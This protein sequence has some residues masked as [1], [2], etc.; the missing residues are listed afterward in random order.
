M[1]FNTLLYRLGIDPDSFINVENDP[2]KTEE[3]FI[4]EVRQRTDERTC[5]C[6]GNRNTVIND[7]DYVEINCSENDYIS[8]ILRIRKVRFKCKRCGKT[9]TPPIKGIEPYAKT[10]GQTVQMIY[11][12]F[13]KP[14]TFSQIAERYGMSSARVLQ[15]FDE[16]ISYVP[17]R[18]FPDVLC[19]D[20]I[21]FTQEYDQKYC[22]VL[23]GFKERNIIDII[24]NRQ[25]PYLMEY[26][27]S[28]PQS[29]R[30][31][32]KYFISDM[33]DGYSTVCRRYFPNA[34]HIID[35]FH[36]ITQMTSAVNR[37]RT[38][39]MKSTQ[40]GSLYHNFMKAHWKV[41]LCRKSDIPNR[42]YTPLHSSHPYHFEDL[43]FDCVKLDPVFLK[44][45]NIL[46][47]LYRYDQSL[48]FNDALSF[49]DFISSRLIDSDD[50]I[51]MSVGR[52]YHKWRVG[53]ANG[54]AKSQ[55]H[56]RFTNA[57]A[58]SL[59]NQLKT[60]IKAAYGYHNFERFRKRA[61]LIISY[62]KPK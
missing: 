54:L 57:I 41:F 21:K 43:V 35:L 51:L 29:E 30:N 14:L 9:F 59:N 26:F 33:Y 7:Y 20:E 56:S 60:I 40:K 8:D 19:I 46:Q 25:L 2:I 45:Y 42:F 5:P 44:A 34:I 62:K 53:I 39:V 61:L 3:G 22:C 31:R 28:V 47:D 23:Y 38:R 32:V 12:D 50:D 24:K 55:N 37:I 48:S 6:C 27:E 1:N 15:I 10:S 16:K 52:T 11:N 4:Y 18:P 17:R 49:I 36:I 13:T 58:E